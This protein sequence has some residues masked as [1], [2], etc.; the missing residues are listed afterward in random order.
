MVIGST[1]LSNSS[2]AMSTGS[3]MVFGTS[4]M[5]GAPME[6]WSDLAPIILAFS[7]LVYY[8]STVR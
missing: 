8:I 3:I 7:N 2:I 5:T 4:I 6:I 1:F